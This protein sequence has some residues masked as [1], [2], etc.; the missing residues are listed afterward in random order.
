MK[1]TLTLKSESLTS[2]SDS[3]LAGVV[4]GEITGPSCLVLSCVESTPARC[5][6]VTFGNC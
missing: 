5:Y 1:R 6:W 2:L 3:D 4:G